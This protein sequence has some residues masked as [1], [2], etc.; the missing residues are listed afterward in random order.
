MNLNMNWQ[1]VC[2]TLNRV[3]LRGWVSCACVCVWVT[4]HSVRALLAVNIILSDIFM[5]I[6]D[7]SL[8]F[9]YLYSLLMCK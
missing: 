1:K 9:F 4:L 7:F 3:E 6:K 2:K 8:A 5:V